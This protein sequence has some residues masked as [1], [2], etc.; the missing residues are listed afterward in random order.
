MP[1]VD[2]LD[3]PEG[4]TSRPLA[5]DDAYAVYEV[6]ALQEQHDIGKVEVEPADIVGDWQKPS[7]DVGRPRWA[8]STGTPWSPAPRS[9][10]PAAGM[11]V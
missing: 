10:S 3:M 9:P 2:V 4:L 6:M 5:M 11:P 7:F 8:S 1:G